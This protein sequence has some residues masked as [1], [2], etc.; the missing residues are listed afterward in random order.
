MRELPP[1]SANSRVTTP[2]HG[3][4]TRDGYVFLELQVE[5][6]AKKKS[7]LFNGVVT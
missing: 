4:N 7:D 2:G 5:E 6:N 1:T 3:T